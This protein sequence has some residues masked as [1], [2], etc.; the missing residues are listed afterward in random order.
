M[1]WKKWMINLK[2][3]KICC[4]LMIQ[5]V[6]SSI[7]L[8][9]RDFTMIDRIWLFLNFVIDETVIVFIWIFWFE[10]MKNHFNSFEFRKFKKRISFKSFNHQINQ[11]QS[12]LL[13]L[14]WMR[15]FTQLFL[16]KS[17]WKN[18]SLHISWKFK[19]LLNW[20]NLSI[21]MIFNHIEIL[22][23]D[24]NISFINWKEDRN[25]DSDYSFNIDCFL[26]VI[27]ISLSLWIK[28]S[29][30]F[31]QAFEWKIHLFQRSIDETGIL[32]VSCGIWIKICLSNLI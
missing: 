16:F 7:I 28:S 17:I 22:Q 29:I 15:L 21:D 19:Y 5:L 13:N 32:Y 2:D 18:L 23:S 20:F 30:G 1:I 14:E 9:Q 12:I 26:N 3:K 25:F 27:K 31:Q 8:F 24:F 10:I 11:F 4:C 6:V